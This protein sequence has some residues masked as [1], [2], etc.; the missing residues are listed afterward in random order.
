MIVADYD[1][2][3]A[4]G[5]SVAEDSGP[6]NLD[7]SYLGDATPDGTGDAVF[8]GNGDYILVDPD[9]SLELTEG[10][11]II[12]F[13]Q[14]T[15]SPGDTPWSGP[16]GAHTLFSVD[17]TG[18]GGG[19]HLSIYI[20]SSGQLIVRHQD[21]D[22]EHYYF[23]GTVTP[24]E[25][26]SI[27][28]SWSPTGS[29]LVVNGTVVDSGTDPLILNG[30]TEPMII[31][32]GQTTST[33]GTADQ[34]NGFFEGDISRVQIH[35]E[36]LITSS[37][38][39][40]FVTGTLILTPKGD[41]AVQN[42][43][44]GDLVTT[45]DHGPQPVLSIHRT[46]INGPELALFPKLRPI[47]IRR[48]A[49]GNARNLLVSRQHCL[50][51]NHNDEEVLIRAAHLERFGG[52]EFRMALGRNKVTYHHLLFARHEILMANG[53]YAESLLP[54]ANM[55]ALADLDIDRKAVRAATPFPNGACRRICSAKEAKHIL[56]ERRR[57]GVSPKPSHP[58]RTAA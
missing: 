42:L 4:S 55:P 12:E 17:A 57:T 50:L 56:Q 33:V 43:S 1:F 19:G 31:G 40:C 26:M 7:G 58:G 27:G 2:N 34:I 38:V 52:G 5:G 9:P 20:T 54:C 32:A 11:V 25:P 30:G 8:D 53:A 46:S 18:Y 28:Y 29:T 37:P 48:G 6:S 14:A 15:T 41:V 47:S 35:D 21:A 10:T 3:E 36:A 16:P 51:L 24:G 45:L 23:G 22:S 49:L 44:A 39:P 13:T